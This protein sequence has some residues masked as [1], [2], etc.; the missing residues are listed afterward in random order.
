MASVPNFEALFHASNHRFP[1]QTIQVRVPGSATIHFYH[2]ANS[3]CSQKVRAVLLET[4]QPFVSHILDIFKG[5]T[6]DPNYVRMRLM[7]CDAA[8][9]PL[10]SNHPGTTSVAT[11]G[12]DAC[13]VPTIADSASGE[14][15]VD[16]KNICLELDRRNPKGPGALMPDEFRDAIESELAVVDNLPNYQ[17]LAVA[18]GKPNTEAADNSFAA[19]KVRRCDAMI[20]ENA[21]DRELC[22]AYAAKRAKEQTAAERLFDSAAMDRARVIIESALEQLDSRLEKHGGPYLFG[23]S[24]TMADLF[25]GVELIRNDD[26]GLSLRWSNGQLPSLAAYY[27]RISQLPSVSAA[28]IEW[29][30]ARLKIK[31]PPAH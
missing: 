15:L 13:V 5:D 31:S 25:W 6:Y 24:L 17:L 21:D 4:G 22:R 14:V 20:A 27:Q 7:G 8:G 11:T 28:V 19:S 16:S 3:I 18:V 10:A 12:C 30:G 26:L 1:G 23:S 29:P 9:L 2:A